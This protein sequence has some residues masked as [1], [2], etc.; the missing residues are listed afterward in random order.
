MDLTI[1]A[2]L[3]LDGLTN[4][5]IYAL[6]AL[7][8]VLVFSV[9]RVIFIPQGEFVAF[10]ALTL[11]ALQTGKV[12]G[13]VWLLLMM[14]VAAAVLD[15]S[16]GVRER[17]AIGRI[18]QRLLASL[19]VPG[20]IAA[21]ACVMAPRQPSL[22]VQVALTLAIVTA[23]GP[24]LYRLAYRALSGASVLTLLIVSVGVHFAMTGMGLVLF[25]PEG[26]RTPAFWEA[27]F[28]VGPLSFSGQTLII[29]GATAAL[30]VAMFVFF[31]RTLVGKAL[32]A[33]SV[34]RTGARLMGIS[35]DA[36][37]SLSFTMAAFI[38]ALSGLLISHRRP[39]STYD[40]GFLIGL[41][42]FVAAVFGGLAS[43]P[44]ALSRR[45]RRRP[46]RELR[47]VLG[48]RVQGGHRVHGDPADPP[49]AVLRG[50]ASRGALTI[51]P[52]PSVDR[53]CDRAARPALRAS[54][55]LLDHP[56]QLH[57]PVLAGCARPGAVDWRGRTHVLRPGCLSPA[58]APTPPA[59]V[60]DDAGPVAVAGPRRWP[61][62]HAGA[63]PG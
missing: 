48:E 13:T 58:S 31:E 4:G 7:A 10:G 32:R 53:R 41:K 18:A 2:I 19:V 11:A 5:A 26:Y 21:L 42:G 47:L 49:L 12:P 50:P 15:L 38:G 28:D 40:T 9:T 36:A 27:R 3:G 22:I 46:D 17:W 51:D 30:L 62:R 8:L 52:N 29:F 44:M 16:Q 57:R 20:A 1:A 45:P 59:Y 56:A 23:M 34:N 25:G 24:L 14:A 39:P 54:A 37:G 60:S 61:C 35:G 63:G 6:V 43:F 55:G 33:T